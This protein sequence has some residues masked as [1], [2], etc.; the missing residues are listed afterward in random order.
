M[1]TDRVDVRL[2]SYPSLT[3]LTF[4]N[5]V[6]IFDDNIPSSSPTLSPALPNR[7]FILIYRTLISLGC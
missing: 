6:M 3:Q 1:T 4:F 2:P 5:V 7:L